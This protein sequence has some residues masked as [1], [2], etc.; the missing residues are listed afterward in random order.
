MCVTLP[1]LLLTFYLVGKFIVLFRKLKANEAFQSCFQLFNH[2]FFV[3][4]LAGFVFIHADALCAESLDATKPA[5]FLLMVS[6]GGS[7]LGLTLLEHWQP[8]V[9]S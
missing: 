4:L 3:F 8:S 1:A 2:V 5:S 7:F 6:G 9:L